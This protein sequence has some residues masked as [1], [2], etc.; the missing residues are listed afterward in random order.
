MHLQPTIAIVVDGTSTPADKSANRQLLK[1]G[2]CA[3]NPSVSAIG[4]FQQSWP[5]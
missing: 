2:H 4:I 3:Q 5:P 1:S